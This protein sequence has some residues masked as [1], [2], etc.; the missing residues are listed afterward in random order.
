MNDYTSSSSRVNP[1]QV[2]PVEQ[3]TDGEE[4]GSA[5]GKSAAQTTYVVFMTYCLEKRATTK[6]PIMKLKPL[7]ISTRTKKY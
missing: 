1:A 2:F 4:N 6:V 7:V 3:K 5:I